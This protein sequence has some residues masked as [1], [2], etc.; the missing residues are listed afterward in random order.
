[1]G[2]GDDSVASCRCTHLT[3]FTVWAYAPIGQCGEP[4]AVLLSQALTIC[5]LCLAAVAGELLRS[6]RLPVYD[7]LSELITNTIVVSEAFVHCQPRNL[8][9][10]THD[11]CLEALT[12]VCSVS[13]AVL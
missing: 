10:W 5:L 11:V 9:R 1:M 12:C 3:D 4:Q 13:G 8:H 7:P 2:G 6:E